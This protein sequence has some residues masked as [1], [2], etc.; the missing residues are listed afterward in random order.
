MVDTRQIPN[1]QNYRSMEEWAQQLY[2]F[3]STNTRFEQTNNPIPI[4]LPHIKGNVTARATE[5]GIL[6]YDPSIDRVVVSISGAYEK[7]LI[8]DDLP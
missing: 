1:P 2:Y 8:E 5:N 4:L 7:L 6:L 3:L